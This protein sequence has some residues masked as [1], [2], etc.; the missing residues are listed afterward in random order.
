MRTKITVEFLAVEKLE[1]PLQSRLPPKISSDDD[2]TA[3]ADARDSSGG[4]TN[5]SISGA[6]TEKVPRFRDIVE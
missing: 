6:R 1:L 3:Y 5:V 4:T 2:E